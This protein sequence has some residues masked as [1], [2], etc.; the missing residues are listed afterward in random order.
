LGR[1]ASE[2]ELALAEEFLE[3]EAVEDQQPL[4]GRGESGEGS[5]GDEVAPL[6]RQQKWT[7][8]CQSLYCSLDFRYLK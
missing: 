4:P 5:S 7:Q 6:T 2:Q 1:S 8:L 3:A